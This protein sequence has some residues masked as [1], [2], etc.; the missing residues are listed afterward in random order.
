MPTWKSCVGSGGCRCHAEVKVGSVCSCGNI[1]G[2]V[3][4][5]K[6]S[7]YGSATVAVSDSAPIHMQTGELSH[8]RAV[9]NPLIIFK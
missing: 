9:F 7:V 6:S 3:A 1:H 8:G 4:A 2:H 5:V